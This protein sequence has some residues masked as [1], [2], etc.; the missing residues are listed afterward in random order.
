M[1]DKIARLHQ[2]RQDKVRVDAEIAEYR[3]TWEQNMADL[4]TE[5]EMLGV[6]ITDLEADI[7]AERVEDYDGEDKSKLFGVSIRETTVLDYDK[8]AA[9]DWAQERGLALQ[10]DKRLFEKLAKTGPTI[11]C[12]RKSQL[13]TATIATDLSEYLD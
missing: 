11:A 1:K 6:G 4:F 8:A 3:A 7:K 12:V 5:K 10:L 13:I 9:L 2:L